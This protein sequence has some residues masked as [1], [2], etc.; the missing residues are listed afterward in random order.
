MTNELF[1]E[2]YGLIE[3]KNFRVRAE[4]GFDLERFFMVRDRFIGENLGVHTFPVEE[5]FSGIIHIILL[6]IPATS[7]IDTAVFT[8]DAKSAGYFFL[9]LKG[10]E[11]MFTTEAAKLTMF[12]ELNMIIP[13]CEVRQ[14][15]KE[16]AGHANK[17]FLCF[18]GMLKCSNGAFCEL[19]LR[20]KP[21]GIL[22]GRK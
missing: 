11:V 8:Q 12:P 22:L 13:H 18:D 4:E 9:G 3:R 10:V 21:Y 2:K 17:A 7:R 14:E 1:L 5:E 15:D 19:P 16:F 6:E 20:Q